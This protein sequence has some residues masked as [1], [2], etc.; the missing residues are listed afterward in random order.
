MS[1]EPPYSLVRVEDALWVVTRPT[2]MCRYDFAFEDHFACRHPFRRE[3]V[4]RAV[5]RMGATGEYAER[6]NRLLGEGVQLIHTPAE[7]E[8]T[9][10]LP[11][12]YPRLADHTPRSLWFDKRPSVEDVEAA[13]RWPIF[14]KGARQTNKHQRHLSILENRDDFERAMDWWEADPILGWQQIVCRE[15]VPLRLVGEQ[16]SLTLPRAFEFRSFWWGNECVGIG[17][18][19]VDEQYELTPDERTAAL[20]IAGEA[21]RRVGVQ[22]LVVDVA[23]KATGEW[24]VIECND[25]QDAG[26]AGI[27]ALFVWR[28]IVV[29][30]QGR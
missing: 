29:L 10:Q 17:P 19:W 25:G 1:R 3:G 14:V 5:A 30:A 21:A 4:V 22:F 2:G 8:P 7:Y 23:Q 15:F 6:Y 12:W 27:A 16:S 18:Y 11:G 13:F 28:H 24:I 26:Y 9:S 20:A